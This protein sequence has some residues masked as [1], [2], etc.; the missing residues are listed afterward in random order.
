M[1]MV[2]ELD[3]HPIKCGLD[4]DYMPGVGQP[5]SFGSS[6]PLRWLPLGSYGPPICRYTGCV[7]DHPGGDCGL[8]CTQHERLHW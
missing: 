1:D 7:P 2:C 4:T 5:P 6:L 3:N 8:D